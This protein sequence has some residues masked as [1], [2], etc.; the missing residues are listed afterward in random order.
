MP[1]G[2]QLLTEGFDQVHAAADLDPLHLLL[3]RSAAAG[4]D[5]LAEVRA[6]FGP[7]LA[8]VFAFDPDSPD[9][10]GSFA[11]AGRQLT[12]RWSDHGEVFDHHWQARLDTETCETCGAAVWVKVT[13]AADLLAVY[14]GQPPEELF[15]DHCDVPDWYAA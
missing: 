2:G 15:C 5:P 10:T 6:T 3:A 4:L 1:T 12:V 9:S 13:D 14:N 8:A 7:D 11:V